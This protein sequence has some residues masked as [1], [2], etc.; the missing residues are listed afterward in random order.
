MFTLLVFVLLRE[1]WRRTVEA[2][3]DSRALHRLQ[4]ALGRPT[5]T[6]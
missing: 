2:Q 3:R 4:T 6:R 5:T 1:A